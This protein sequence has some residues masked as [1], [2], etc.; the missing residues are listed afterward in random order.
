MQIVENIGRIEEAT[1]DL[2]FDSPQ[3]LLGAVHHC[4]NW[5]TNI[6]NTSN[7]LNV[8]ISNRIFPHI[9]LNFIHTAPNS[10][11]FTQSL[12]DAGRHCSHRI[13]GMIII[14]FHA[15]FINQVLGHI[16][17]QIVC[18]FI[19]PA[20]SRVHTRPWTVAHLLPCHFC[21]QIKF[22]EQEGRCLI[23]WND[24]SP[25]STTSFKSYDFK[26]KAIYPFR[27]DSSS[28]PSPRPPPYLS[29]KRQPLQQILFC[30]SVSHIIN[31]LIFSFSVSG[32]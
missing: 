6:I 8:R 13:T 18:N 26:L 11:S 1:T 19:H 2:S 12:F 14:A 9:P 22:S 30:S 5:I 32:H 31:S 4:S 21:Y 27:N 7:L 23:K 20:L 10:L 17:F 16:S 24:Y 15:V 25:K 29:E 28:P 3:S